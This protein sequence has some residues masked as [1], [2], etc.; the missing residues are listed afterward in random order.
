MLEL[1]IMRRLRGVCAVLTM[2]LLGSLAA[3]PTAGAQSIDPGAY[4]KLKTQFRGKGMCLDVY[5]GGGKNNMTHL[6][7]CA[8]FSGQFWRF[9]PAKKGYYK[10][11]TLFRGESMCLDI[12]NGGGRNNQPH[13]VP[14]ANYSGQFWR[15]HFQN[16]WVRLTTEFRGK[17]VCLDIFNGGPN[18]NMPHLTRCQKLS[19]QFWELKRTNKRF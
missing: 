18:N 5:N 14:C 3:V 16:G 17:G 9:K 4:Y 12:Y 15:V 2:V 7:K 6:V 19:G 13:L 10:L 11:K 1:N 8:N